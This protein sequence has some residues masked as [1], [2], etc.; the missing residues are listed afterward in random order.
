MLQYVYLNDNNLSGTIPASFGNLTSLI[1]LTL[2]TNNLSGDIPATLGNCKELALVYLHRNQLTG[3]IPLFFTT[4]PKL[5]YLVLSENRFTGEIPP[6]SNPV[7]ASLQLAYNQLTGGIPA[8]FGTMTNLQYVNAGN[9]KLDGQIAPELNNIPGLSQLLLNDNA[10]KD[11]PNFALHPN[12]ASLIVYLSYN[13][14][15]FGDLEPLFTAPGV[16]PFYALSWYPQTISD[17]APVHVPLGETV[18]LPSRPAG[19]NSTIT[20]E[21]LVNNVWTNVNSLNEDATHQTFRRSNASHNMEDSYRWRMTNSLVTG[22]TLESKPIELTVVDALRTT[23]AT[24]LYNGII[25]TARWRTSKAY[26]VEGEDL[27]GMYVFDYDDKYQIRD[28]SWAT[29]TSAW[30]SFSGNKYRVTGMDYDP[31]GNI[32]A[33]IRYDKDALRTHNFTHDYE[34]NKNKLKSVSG[35]TNAYTYNAIGQ[36][37]GEDKAEEGKDQYVEYDV[38]G[39]VTKVFSDPAKL[40]AHLKVEYLYDDRGFRLAK[41]NHQSNRTTWYIRDGSGNVISIY[42]QEGIPG[43]TNAD[44]ITLVE[45]PVYGSGKLG[46]LYPQQ[47]S[48]MNYE[49][50]DHLGNVRALLRDNVNVYTA[51]MED[52]GQEALSNPRVEEMAYF[53]NL[54][55]TAVTDARM[56]HTAPVAG[57][58]APDKAAYLFWNDTYGTLAEQ[59]AIGPAIALKVNAGDSVDIEAWTRYE[60]KTSFAKDFDLVALSS[61]LG[62]SFTAAGGFEGYTMNQTTSSLQSALAAGA[63]PDD[64]GDDTRPFAYLSYILYDE[65]MV[66]QD[67]GWVRVTDDAGFYAEEIGLPE[68]KPVRIAFDNAIGIPQNGYI[69]VWLSNQSKETRVW[70]D[71]LQ[72]THTQS[73]VV[74]ATDYG[75]WGD[76]LREQKADESTYRF[77][78]Q[79]QFSERDLE[80]GWSHFELREYDPVIGRWLVTDPYG[81]YWS[82]YVGMGNDPVNSVDPNGG[83]DGYIR[84]SDGTVSYL[85]GDGGETHDIIY[86]QDGTIEQVLL[87][88]VTIRSLRWEARPAMEMLAKFM[89]NY[90][91]V[92]DGAFAL[93]GIATAAN[94]TAGMYSA[95]R[96]DAVQAEKIAAEQ[97]AKKGLTFNTGVLES[98]TKHA[99]AGGRHADLG[100]SVETMASKGLNLVK[101][102]MSLLKAGDNTLIGNINGIQKSFKTFVQDGKI[103][104]VN[105]YPGA[106]NRTTQGTVINFG[107][108]TW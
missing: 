30:Y 85:N 4:L 105:M 107:N 14:L 12:R 64:G 69:Y 62:S 84:N 49:I 55:E 25:S 19:Q 22:L 74:Q 40:A 61:L 21:R 24:P 88:E 37:T 75:V 80:T 59:K 100:L 53:E 87:N 106:S 51:T 102:N 86:R 8:S 79:G 26:G 15:D 3:S 33:L 35:Y 29:H 71:D 101:Q 23:P 89:T 82:P 65:N 2:Q 38:S 41:V 73:L 98:F 72:V 1:H 56:N 48:S 68:K 70:F 52:N 60:R 13:Q 77:G 67:A 76:V 78:Y 43:Q 96:F 10:L 36:M 42:E 99:F 66:Y 50:T 83:R 16:N 54:F 11:I 28:A 9:N 18:V 31:N 32:K 45:V 93:D 6:F 5:Y 34:P 91:M 90:I 92:M 46:T 7:L 27:T 47:D 39:K 94:Y 81:Q 58:E 95:A 44:A 57:V 108:V 97:A 103:M 17:G 104:S 63:Y 20:W